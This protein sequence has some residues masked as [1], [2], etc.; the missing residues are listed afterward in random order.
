MLSLW[1]WTSHLLEEELLTDK[2]VYLISG[3]T[4]VNTDTRI[5]N[6][7]QEGHNV[8]ALAHCAPW[9]LETDWSKFRN[10]C[11]GDYIRRTEA[12][13]CWRSFFLIWLC[14]VVHVV[15]R[16]SSGNSLCLSSFDSEANQIA[17]SLDDSSSLLYTVE[18][19]LPS[20]WKST[21]SCLN[22]WCFLSSH[23][24]RGGRLTVAVFTWFLDLC[25]VGVGWITKWTL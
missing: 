17:P 6:L 19:P 5:I 1:T 13:V 9:D 24:Q 22:S 16:V 4:T 3:R 11:R 20:T 21:K 10:V 12:L 25:F 15:R 2:S 7:I 14:V 23:V 8:A 18:H